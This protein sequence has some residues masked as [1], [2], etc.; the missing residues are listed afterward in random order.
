MI[1]SA[2][3]CKALTVVLVLAAL[4]GCDRTRRPPDMPPLPPGAPEP[5]TAAP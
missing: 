4:C 5:R 3:L 2:S 1:A